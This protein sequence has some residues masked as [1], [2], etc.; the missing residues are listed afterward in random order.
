VNVFKLPFAL[1]TFLGFV[2]M[3]PIWMW[4]VNSHP[5][6]SSLPIEAQFL[7]GLVLPATVAL[8]T[9]SWLGGG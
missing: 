2:A 3:V 6:G 8:F 5:N 7:A 1:L 9:A 4:F